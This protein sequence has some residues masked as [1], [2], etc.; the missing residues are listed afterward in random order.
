LQSEFETI[1]GKHFVGLYL[2]GSLAMGGFNPARSDIDLL[3]LMDQRSTAEQKRQL[4]ELLLRV[5]KA[6]SPVEITF[7]VQE[8]LFPFQSPLRYD[9]H[10]REKWRERY[11]QELRNGTWEHW[12]NAVRHDNDL[13]IY[14]MLLRHGGIA[15]Y[16]P[17][18]AEAL[19]E[20]PERAFRD[21]LL[22]HSDYERG[23]RMRDPVAF[24]LDGCRD[25][26]YVH[27]G[28]LLSKDGGGE[29]GLE[30]LPEAYQGLVQQSL[31]LYRG[32]RLGRPVGRT[33]L[34]EFAQYIQHDLQELHT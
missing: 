14:L 16:G 18:I 13:T 19:P 17:S 25:S 7:V 24:V 30:H 20:V 21:A 33:V 10:F 1:L 27:E 28:V 9:L 3:V 5:S 34:E 15:L 2:H 12:N 29:W 22:T 11:G 23:E 6:P 4:I 32:D 31:A 26:A 8:D